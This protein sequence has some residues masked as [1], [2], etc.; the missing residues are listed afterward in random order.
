MKKVSL[1]ILDWFGINE[2][3]PEENS[4]T[5][6]ENRPNFSKLFAFPWYTRLKASWRNVWIVDGFMW[7]SEVWHLTIWAGK[8]VKQNILE[9]ND[10]LD[11]TLNVFNKKIEILIKKRNEKIHS[12]D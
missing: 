2:S 1:I 8:I 10:L 12:A 9:I 4:I 6:A 11:S 5:Q 3:T 7:G